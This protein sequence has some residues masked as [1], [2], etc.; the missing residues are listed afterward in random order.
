MNKIPKKYIK[1]L[2]IVLEIYLA[3]FLLGLILRCFIVS[4]V[5]SIYVL[6][7]GGH[8]ASFVF[9]AWLGVYAG[10]NYKRRWFF[11]IVGVLVYYILFY[12][13][14]VTFTLADFNLSPNNTGDIKVSKSN[15][16]VVDIKED[17]ANFIENNVIVISVAMMIAVLS[18]II[19][20]LT[21]WKIAVVIRAVLIAV[22]VAA[23]TVPVGVALNKRYCPTYYKYPDFFIEGNTISMVKDF[24]GE[25]DI[26]RDFVCAYYTYTDE[27]GNSWYYTMYYEEGGVIRKIQMEIF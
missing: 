16:S 21:K 3:I 4:W 20:L 1:N 26:K 18:F 24:F 6:F 9:A 14:F 11:P 22:V 2:I 13:I 23:V 17:L 27:E 19:R 5:L 12:L 10:N 25:F 15:G 8:A 7:Y